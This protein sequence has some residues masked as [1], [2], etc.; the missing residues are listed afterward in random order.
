LS[1]SA[2]EP[3]VRLLSLYLLDVLGR[4]DPQ[5]ERLVSE[6]KGALRS[7][8]SAQSMRRVIER[9][10]E[11][12]ELVILA[13]IVGDARDWLYGEGPRA[14]MAAAVSGPAGDPPGHGTPE[15]NGLH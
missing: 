2:R 11:N 15:G 6:G 14:P 1:G 10:G 9:S 5:V 7:A 13:K 8:Y 3:V 4:N 12:M